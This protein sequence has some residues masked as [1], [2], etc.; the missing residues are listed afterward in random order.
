[1]R[2]VLQLFRRPSWWA[3]TAFAAVMVLLFVGL[4]RW[5]LERRQTQAEHD[6]AEAAAYSLPAAPP[7]D[8]L[9]TDRPADRDVVGRAVAATGSFDAAHQVLVRNRTLDGRNGYLVV[10]PLE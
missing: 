3:F 4:A 2:S 9:S 8:F 1:M 5:Q 6:S 10:T 7:A